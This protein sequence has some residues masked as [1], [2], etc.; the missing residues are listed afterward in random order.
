MKNKI[1]FLI[2]VL[3]CFI[4]S[5]AAYASY[6][7]TQNAPVDA[8]NA[9]TISI[10]DKNEKNYTLTK[11]KENDDADKMI[12]FF[13]SMKDNAQQIVALPDSLMGEKFFIVKI[14][15]AVNKSDTYEFYFSKDPTANYFRASDGTTYKIS[16]TDAAQFITS[17]YAESLYEQSAMPVLTLSHAYDVT[18]DTAVWQYKNYTGDYVDS[19]VTSLVSSAVESYDIEGGL[20]LTFDVAPDNC[21]VTVTDAEGNVL[22]EDALAALSTFALDVTKEVTVDVTATWYEDPARSF[23]G[24]LEYSFMSLVSAPA[25][26]YLG[27]TT[28]ESGKFT[29]ITALNV[30]KPENI[31][32]S[33]TMETT[34][35]APQPVFYPAG[36]NMAVALLPIP[37]DTPSGA[38]TL[39]F[40]YG[41][42]E[43]ETVLTVEHG[44]EKVSYYTVSEA[45]IQM[46]RTAES[47]QQFDEVTS[48]LMAGGSSE[49]Y[50]SGHF[51]EGINGTSRL[52][53][54]FGRDIYLN[55]A[56]TPA[57]TNNGV[58]YEAAAGTEVVAC[59]AGEVVYAGYLDYA[60]N[61]VVIEHGYGLK[62]W[63][64]N[65]GSI[66]AAVGDRVER[67]TAIGTTG[68][69]GF[70][71]FTGAHI[72]MS[73]GSTFVS[74]YDTWAD[75]PIAGKVIIA[76]IDE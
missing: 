67:G 19:D 27:M 58:D 50:F 18:P 49:R 31:R 61:M 38:Y 75:S 72:A 22:F 57:Y 36:G 26:F 65:L 24:K 14:S 76:K 70:T 13:L 32:F 23:C 10:T 5:V 16:E 37:A 46:T 20:D 4:P 15:T 42:V 43:Q 40:S 45:I 35:G 3:A 6:H 63:Y 74:P 17:E 1:V 48:E 2:V 34:E 29:A 11:E 25:E 28:V 12:R 53:R 71:G 30:S 47:L 39:K 54:G 66:S 33:S 8:N 51:L 64:Y 73:V 55:N 7:Q 41:T 69:T 68:Q 9:V 56:T 52:L 21:T 59:N 44:G 60:G 62:T